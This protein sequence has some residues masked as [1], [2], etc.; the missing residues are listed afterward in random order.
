MWPFSYRSIILSIRVSHSATFH[1]L[2]VRCFFLLPM[3]IIFP[4]ISMNGIKNHHLIRSLYCKNTFQVHKTN[5]SLNKKPIPTRLLALKM[6]SLIR[7]LSTAS[8]RDRTS[9]YA[10]IIIDHSWSASPVLYKTFRSRT[11]SMSRSTLPD[12]STTPFLVVTLP[13]SWCNIILY[14]TER[15]CTEGDRLAYNHTPYNAK[16]RS[17]SL[18]CNNR[19]R[20]SDTSWYI[21]SKYYPKPLL[22][23]IQFWKIH[24]INSSRGSITNH[25]H[26]VNFN[27]LSRVLR[28]T[29]L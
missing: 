28:V 25:N 5:L 12:W 18:D 20:L 21:P 24:I 29:F 10:Q 6:Q 26:D 1:F 27:V 13:R 7:I 14:C 2:Q 17:R 23:S 11:S 8:T 16:V 4:C 15:D 3:K 19:S 22:E 9:F